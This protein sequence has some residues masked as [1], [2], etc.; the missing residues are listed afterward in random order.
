MIFKDSTSPLQSTID[1]DFSLPFCLYPI[2][3]VGIF[4]D[5]ASKI[6][7]EELPKIPLL[8]AS[9]LINCL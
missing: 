4:K 8:L 2:L 1:L 5:G 7:L 3:I 6:P 9:N